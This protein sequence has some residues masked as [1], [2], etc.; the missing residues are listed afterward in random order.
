MSRSGKGRRPD[1]RIHDG[2]DDAWDRERSRANRVENVIGGRSFRQLEKWLEERPINVSYALE[3][4]ILL[5]NRAHP[6]VHS[7]HS[8]VRSVKADVWDKTG[9]LCYYCETRLNPFRDFSVDHVIPASRGG[10]SGLENL[11]PACESC[12]REKGDQ[13]WVAGQRKAT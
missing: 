5:R 11:V 7:R 6:M 4:L 9:G 10:G 2:D 3:Y 12:N 13:V 1:P 8:I